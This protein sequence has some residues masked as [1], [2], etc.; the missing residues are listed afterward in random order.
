MLFKLG[1]Y[2]AAIRHYTDVFRRGVHPTEVGARMHNNLGAAYLKT[3]RYDDAVAEFRRAL[4][5]DPTYVEPYYNLG[6][7][8]MA[9]GRR[10]EAADVFR[11]GLAQAPDH[12]ALRAQL[13]AV[14]SGARP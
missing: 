12:P 8:L 6:I 5:I 14:E 7:V 4:T 3:D 10:G 11:Q 9:F 2:D 13:A 1:R